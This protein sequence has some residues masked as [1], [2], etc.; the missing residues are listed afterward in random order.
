MA[1]GVPNFI[2]Q[3]QKIRRHARP[4]LFWGGHPRTYFF[5]KSNLKIQKVNSWMPA[6]AGMTVRE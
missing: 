2:L 5:I 6:F 1:L 3:K 4:K